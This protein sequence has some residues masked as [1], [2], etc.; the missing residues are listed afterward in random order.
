MCYGHDD[1]GK[2]KTIAKGS[3]SSYINIIIIIKL[4]IN[5]IWSLLVELFYKQLRVRGDYVQ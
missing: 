4:I 1:D 5:M 2:F 3:T